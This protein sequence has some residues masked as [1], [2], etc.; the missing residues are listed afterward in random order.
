MVLCSAHP[1]RL[2]LLVTLHPP[3]KLFPKQNITNLLNM[4]LLSRTHAQKGR[5]NK[6]PLEG[7]R[8]AFASDVSV[9]NAQTVIRN[10]VT[11]YALAR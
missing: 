4:I 5:W 8:F 6:Y 11:L 10:D 2:Y 9:L 7:G 3:I 1:S